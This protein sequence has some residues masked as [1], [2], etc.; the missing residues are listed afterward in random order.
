[1]LYTCRIS[2]YVKFLFSFCV[3]Q[4]KSPD[5]IRSVSFLAS[6]KYPWLASFFPRWIKVPCWVMHLSSNKFWGV[7]KIS[8]SNI[9]FEMIQ[10]LIMTSLS[11]V[12]GTFK[13]CYDTMLIIM[14]FMMSIIKG[15]L[16]LLL[17]DMLLLFESMWELVWSN[18]VVT[19]YTFLL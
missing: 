7:E 16:L 11:S 15:V 2:E 4:G 9:K 13:F 17:V 10:W 1:M 3:F 14:M 19:Q 8:C 6:Q 18:N 12:F 5:N